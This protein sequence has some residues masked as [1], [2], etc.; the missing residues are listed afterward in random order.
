MIS[1]SEV[2][3]PLSRVKS[4]KAELETNYSHGELWHGRIA[5][6][7]EICSNYRKERIKSRR[8]LQIKEPHGGDVLVLVQIDY[9]CILILHI[10]KIVAEFISLNGT[11]TG[12]VGIH[13][14]SKD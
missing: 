3:K 7:E 14:K 9:I 4:I 1:N 8:H 13:E 12:K 11:N 6:G 10:D 5:I 2:Q